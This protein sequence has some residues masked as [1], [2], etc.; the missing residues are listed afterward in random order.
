MLG[1]VALPIWLAG[2][3]CA[4]FAYRPLSDWSLGHSD[5]TRGERLCLGLFTVLISLS[6]M[7]LFVLWVRS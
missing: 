4:V 2:L 5:P 1:W 6:P 7:A 3:L